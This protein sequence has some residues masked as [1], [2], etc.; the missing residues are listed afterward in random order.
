MVTYRI[1]LEAG[2]DRFGEQLRLSR[3]ALRTHGGTRSPR[4]FMFMRHSS[5]S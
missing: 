4:L 3:D 1:A 5:P 2:T